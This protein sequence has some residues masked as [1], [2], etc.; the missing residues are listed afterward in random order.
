[1]PE[2]H[3]RLSASEAVSEIAAGRLTAEA[4][5]RSCLERI[6]ERE[7]SVAAWT[8]LDP[9]LVMSQARA[10][11]AGSAKGRL[12]GVPIA[13]KDIID[14]AD[15]P[16]TYGSRV[17]QGHRPSRDAACVASARAA[18]AVVMGKT[19]TT[20]FAYRS[21]GPTSNPHNRL[22][23]PGGSSS[24]SAAAVADGM[25]PLA[26]GTQTAGSVIRPA[27]Y[28][29]VFGLKPT[30][31]SFS[32]VGINHLAE[33]FDTLGCMA[34]TLD[35]IALLRS[36]LAG[37]AFEDLGDGP[38]RAP[39]LAFCRTPYWEEATPETQSLVSDAARRL[40]S[41]GANV[42][43]LD[44]KLD[45]QALLDATWVINK[46]EGQRAIGGV[47]D[48]HPDGVSQAIRDLVDEGRKIDYAEY[49]AAM[50]RIDR[51]RQDIDES[52]AEFDAI[53]TPSAVGEAPL[54]LDNTGPIP[55]NFLWTVAGMPAL[56]IPAFTGPNQLPIGLQLV[57]RRHADDLLLRVA[58]WVERR[59]G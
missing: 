38:D 57:A 46:V 52:L 36:V 39:K 12:H 13:A 10:R 55:F 54:G 15:M 58:R 24:G 31:N 50:R 16:T 18:G 2:T 35:D 33:S 1:M 42:V 49:A 20:E 41:A 19:V 14:T 11:D 37:C 22:H 34:R 45:G 43:D 3:H 28:C 9:T 26:L 48:D 32:F 30:F 51:V 8:Y 23:T 47:R 7:P 4:L 5:A 21:P 6:A 40:A 27:A 53:V 17:F 59:L 56:T 29:G 44:L 25:V